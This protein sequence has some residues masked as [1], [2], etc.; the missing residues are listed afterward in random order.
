M[1]SPSS[2]SKRLFL[3]AL[4]LVFHGGGTA[5]PLGPRISGPITA[6]STNYQNAP[7]NTIL[8]LY[9]QLSG[10][11][12]IR[13]ANLSGVPPVSINANGLSKAEM[14]KMIEA[15]LLLNGVAIVPVDEH[16]VKVITVGTNKNP[17]SEGVK[18]YANAVD[19]PTRRRGRQLLHAAQLHQPAG[20]GRLSSS[21]TRRCILTAPMCRRPPRRPSSSRKISA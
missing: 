6:G 9:E 17:R 8:D 13:D 18:L 3:V 7:V 1:A 5:C 16:N 10:K 11:H 12:L 21:R 15:T 4:L 14:I 19:L 2:I 20:S